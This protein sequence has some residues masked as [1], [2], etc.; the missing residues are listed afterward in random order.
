LAEA[1]ADF[2]AT[3]AGDPAP[4]AGTIAC[5]RWIAARLAEVIV[6]RKISEPT[7]ISVNGKIVATLYWMCE[8]NIPIRIEKNTP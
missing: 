1:Y 8:E 6:N 3:A 7:A 2:A 5:S 4:A